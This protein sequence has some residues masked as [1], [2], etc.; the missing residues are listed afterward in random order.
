MFAEL[1]V[2]C[3][4]RQRTTKTIDP[5]LQYI[6]WID[7]ARSLKFASPHGRKKQRKKEPLTEKPSS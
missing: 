7:Q 2:Q 3:I 5:T 6:S 1:N 4:S